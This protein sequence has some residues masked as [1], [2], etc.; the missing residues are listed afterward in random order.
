MQFESK[1][2][3]TISSHSLLGFI[4]DT[5][6]SLLVVFWLEEGALVFIAVFVGLQLL[7]LTRWLIAAAFGW[8][9]LHVTGRKKMAASYSD[10][11]HEH[12]YPEP[13][14]YQKSPED[15]LEETMNNE[16]IDFDV[17]LKAAT[18]F[19]TFVTYRSTGQLQLLFKCSLA[20][21]DAIEEYKRSF[22]RRA[23]TNH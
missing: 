17:R 14:D 6:L 7:Y 16:E 12:K 11:L 21:E 5:L 9:H 3:R 22:T 15:Y 19:G 23:V 13:E 10:Y 2:K 20:M 1:L 8:S 4:P 18:N